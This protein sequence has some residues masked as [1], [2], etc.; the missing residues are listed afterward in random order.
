MEVLAILALAR[1]EASDEVSDELERAGIAIAALMT[2]NVEDEFLGRHLDETE[3][4]VTRLM[5]GLPAP[6]EFVV[7]GENRAEALCNL[8]RAVVRRAEREAMRSGRSAAVVALL[9]RLSSLAFAAAYCSAN[10][11]LP[12]AKPT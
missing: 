9:N 6:S 8:V 2:P 7:P 4:A 11:Q 3:R 12:P 1:T 5:A 10:G